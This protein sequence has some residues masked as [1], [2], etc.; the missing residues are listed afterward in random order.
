MSPHMHCRANHSPLP[1]P[2]PLLLLLLVGMST[3]S[4]ATSCSFQPCFR[5]QSYTPHP[6][7]VLVLPS[8]QVLDTNLVGPFLVAQAVARSMVRDKRSGSI[9]N[10]SSVSSMVPSSGET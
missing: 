10:I 2:L 5:L 7:S 4:G 9:I 6:P 1:L 8:L 3:L